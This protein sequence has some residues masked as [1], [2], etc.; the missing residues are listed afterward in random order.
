MKKKLAL[1]LGLVMLLCG[2]MPSQAET[3]NLMRPP[4]PSGEKAE[5]QQ[6]IEEHT[7]EN[8]VLKYPR[9]G[10]Y[11]SAIITCDVNGDK[12]DEAFAFYQPK[13]SSASGTHF[14][15]MDQFQGKWRVVSEHVIDSG[16][17]DRI[18]VRDLTGTG[19]KEII[20][21]WDTY[22]DTKIM[23]VYDYRN[24]TLRQ[25][26]PEQCLYT[27]VCVGDFD[28]DGNDEL[29]TVAENGATQSA[30]ARLFKMRQGALEQ[31]S[32]IGLDQNVSGYANI[33]AGVINRDGQYGVVLDGYK[34]NSSMITELV[35]YDAAAG[36]LMVPSKDR[37]ALQDVALRSTVTVSRD[38]N[39]DGIVEIPF[40][41]NTSFSIAL[42]E[43][44]QTDYTFWRCFD[45]KNNEFYNVASMFI[46]YSDG[47]YLT[48]PDEWVEKVYA[49][50]DTAGKTV[51]FYQM[52]PLA[53]DNSLGA[54]TNGT[55]IASP[56]F[57]KL[58]QIKVVGQEEWEGMQQE[59]TYQKL[60]EKDGSVFVASVVENRTLSMSFSQLQQNF[61]LIT[62]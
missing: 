52:N 2:C 21:G 40:V 9:S 4:R 28:Q 37:E 10:D 6:V 5:I 22:S 24:N 26:M 61:T 54:Q 51:T 47:Y 42:G 50:V 60:A 27:D 55:G 17:V 35:Y 36:R 15:F 38:M 3:E 34:G 29:L 41:V 57:E 14:V 1:L 48:V 30:Q 19:Q 8:V 31:I 53:L 7:G 25:L 49:S 16:E 46:N 13:S 23:E 39:N 12:K 32:T 56:Y 11:R 44:V 45:V 43:K 18:L 58:L 20:I 59:G 33:R 62:G